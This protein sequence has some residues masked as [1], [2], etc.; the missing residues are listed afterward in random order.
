MSLYVSINYCVAF[1]SC[2][3]S[4]FLKWL[5]Y[6]WI[7]ELVK[8]FVTCIHKM[9]TT[10]APHS[11]LLF[12]SPPPP[13]SSSASLRNFTC[14]VYVEHIVRDSITIEP[15]RT[16]QSVT[17]ITSYRHCQ[18]WRY[19]CDQSIF[20]PTNFATSSSLCWRKKRKKKNEKK[21][22][23]KKERK[24]DDNISNYNASCFHFSR[25]YNFSSSLKSPVLLFAGCYF[26]SHLNRIFT[27]T[28]WNLCTPCCIWTTVS[29]RCTNQCK[30]GWTIKL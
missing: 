17:W 26:S 1:F 18:S 2:R 19:F 10:C 14:T 23:R 28:L 22:R 29:I 25:A 12:F 30:S 7:I 21:R 11:C 4:K 13:H 5:A 8:K 20:Y 3:P 6:T 24:M 27:Y 15:V 16:V 9:Y